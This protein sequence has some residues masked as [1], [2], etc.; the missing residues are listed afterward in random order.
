MCSSIPRSSRIGQ[1]TWLFSPGGVHSPPCIPP[2]IITFHPIPTPTATPR[3]PRGRVIVIAPTRAACETIELALG[4]APRHAARARARRRAPGLGRGRQGLRHR[5]RHRRPAR[6]SAS[7]RSPRR[8]CRSRC[9]SAWSTASARRRRRRRRGT[10]SSSPPASRAAGS[11]TTS[12]PAATR[13]SWTRSTRPPPSSSSAWRSASAPG[14][15]SSGSAPPST[16]P[17]TRATSTAPTCCATQAFDPGAP[18][19]VEV[20]PQTARGVPRRASSCATHPRAARRGG[21]PADPRRGG[22]ARRPTREQW[23]KLT[24]AFYH[25]G[26][27]I[28]VIRPFLEGEVERPFLLAMTAAGQSAL[29]VRGPRHRGHLRRALRQRGRSRAQRAAPALPRRQRDPADGRPGARAR[30]ERRGRHPQRPDARLRGA[31]AHAARVPAGRRRRAGGDH[32]R[33]ARRGC[34]RPRP[35][36]AAR[37]HRLP[38]AMELLT[39]RGLVE[40]G[41]LTR[42]GR[43]VEAMPVE[44]PW[45]ELLVHADPELLP[46]VAVCANIDSLHRMTREERDLHGVLVNG[47]DHLT[48]YNL[49][50]E[51]VN[52]C[53]N[54]GEVYGLPRHLFDEEDLAAWAERRGVLVKAIEDTALGAGVGLSRARAA[55]ADAR[56]RMPRRTIRRK[57]IELLARIMPFDLV[58]DEHTADGQEARVSK[59]SVA[60]SWGAVAGQPALLRRPVRHAARGHRGHHDSLRPGAGVRDAGAAARRRHGAAEAPAPRDAPAAGLLRLRPRDRG[61]GDRG[62]RAAARSSSRRAMRW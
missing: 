62:Q 1:S 52:Q 17:S 19:K 14:A 16:P 25:G 56:C 58:I 4:P 10:S 55:A 29:N 46:I 18:A 48:A 37:P 24:A 61:R 2:A 20:V 27:P 41:R 49:Y 53:G 42:Y 34:R 51:A 36:G 22:A 45:A 32:L 28:R 35:A 26:E 54:V 44:R 23:P 40:N 59:T 11:R 33:G 13:W 47:S 38:R 57:W 31:A 9:G 3:I 43:E 15:A 50:A 39:T 7:G 60:G 6:R 8:S 21:V 5:G 12:S 30:A